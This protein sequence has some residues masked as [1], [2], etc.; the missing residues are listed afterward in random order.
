MERLREILTL[1]EVGD[2]KLL[3]VGECGDALIRA[4]SA[5]GRDLAK[6]E[7]DNLAADWEHLVH[8]STERKVD[9]II[10]KTFNWQK[11]IKLQ[12]C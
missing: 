2:A 8:L 9:I 3:D 6:A 11:L 7:M 12:K 10:S 1:K 4:S 5:R